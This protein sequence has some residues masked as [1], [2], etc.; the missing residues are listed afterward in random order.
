MV[1]D[2]SLNESPFSKIRNGEKTVELRLYD[3]KRRKLN[4]GDKIIFTN[5]SNSEEQVAVIIKAL[6]IYGSFREL[7]EDISPE[8]C[9]NSA[10]NSVEELV[11]RMRNYYSETDEE[12]F[13]VLGI[14]IELTSLSETRKEQEEI[15]EAMFDRYFPDGMK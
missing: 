7:F 1:Y 5:L 8:R 9:G 11:A 4:V 2:M 12:I 3:Y 6:Y 14:K 10:D 13:G 15:A